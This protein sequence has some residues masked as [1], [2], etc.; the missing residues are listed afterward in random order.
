MPRQVNPSFASS[1]PPGDSHSSQNRTR[2]LS[3][4][5]K[6][7]EE[8]RAERPKSAVDIFVKHEVDILLVD[9]RLSVLDSDDVLPT[10]SMGT[11][12]QGGHHHPFLA[13]ASPGFHSL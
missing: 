3:L 10:E 7:T 9:L 8:A 2:S 5:T 1:D 12:R 6:K 13:P 11:S 4:T